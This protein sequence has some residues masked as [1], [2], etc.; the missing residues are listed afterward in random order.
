MCK[1]QRVCK[2][3]LA[4]E[5][6]AALTASD[7]AL[8][9]RVL[10][11]EIV[12]GKYDIAAISPPTTYHV[13]DPF[14]PTPTDRE[15]PAQVQTLRMNKQTMPAKRTACQTVRNSHQLILAAIKDWPLRHCG[16]IAR[17]LFRPLLLTDCCS[18]L[19]AI[20]RIHPR[21]QDKCAKLLTNQLRDLQTLIDMSFA[22][23]SCNL[24]DMGTK[25]DASLNILTKFSPLGSFPSLP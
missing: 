2:S 4:A 20:L 13:P 5:A 21:S 18:L 23:D 7:Q 25:H 12:T 1:I 15:V 8:W 3:S 11:T 24:G 6:H 10:I 22:D 16:K 14:S 17:T 9:F 19:S